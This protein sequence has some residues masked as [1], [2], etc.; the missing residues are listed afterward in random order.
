[1][2]PCWGASPPGSTGPPGAIIGQPQAP[3]PVQQQQQQQQSNFD[4]SLMNNGSVVVVSSTSSSSP[5]C[6]TPGGCTVVSGLTV[7]GG[8]GGCGDRRLI[9]P[10]MGPL[11]PPPSTTPLPGGLYGPR[12][13]TMPL[14]HHNPGATACIPQ[15]SVSCLFKNSSH[16]PGIRSQL[17]CSWGFKTFLVVHHTLRLVFTYLCPI[18]HVLRMNLIFDYHFHQAWFLFFD[19]LC[20]KFSIVKRNATKTL[21]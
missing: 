8:G 12:F 16:K 1:M 19:G 4:E 6:S 2:Q 5:T 14:Y 9:T 11:P 17:W 15:Q 21:C 13:A 18:T 10:P 7:A 3:P 20:G